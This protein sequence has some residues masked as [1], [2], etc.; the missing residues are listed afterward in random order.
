MFT[1]CLLSVYELSIDCLYLKQ[2]VHVY[3]V[4]IVSAWE[5]NVLVVWRQGLGTVYGEHLPVWVPLC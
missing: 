2:S 4:F 5:S 3:T 1:L